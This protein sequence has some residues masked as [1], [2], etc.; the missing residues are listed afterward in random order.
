MK[1][2]V[3]GR[4]FNVIGVPTV[5]YETICRFAK[6]GKFASISYRGMRNGNGQLS[7]ILHRGQSV[8]IDDGMS[9]ECVT[10]GNA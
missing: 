5:T 7:G 6:E 2:T 1:I 3:N 4:E 8:D 10:T 9:F